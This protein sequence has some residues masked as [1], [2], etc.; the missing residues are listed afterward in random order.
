MA[1]KEQSYKLFWWSEETPPAINFIGS[2][3]PNDRNY[4]LHKVIVGGL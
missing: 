2:S 1:I 4:F 3:T